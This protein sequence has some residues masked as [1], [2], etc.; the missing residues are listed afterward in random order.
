MNG[1]LTQT[2]EVSGNLHFIANTTVS[3]EVSAQVQSIDVRGNV[4]YIQAAAYP[5]SSL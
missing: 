4:G 2:L 1:D 3:S 5:E